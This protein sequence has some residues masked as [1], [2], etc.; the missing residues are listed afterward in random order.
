MSPEL[1]NMQ[2]ALLMIGNTA[3]LTVDG[4]LSAYGK[5][6]H[7]ALVMRVPSRIYRLVG[8]CVVPRL[9][10]VIFAAPSLFYLMMF[11]K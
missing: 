9:P 3:V 8:C 6:K 5:N 11:S 2:Y 7:I 1:V 4:S 10:R